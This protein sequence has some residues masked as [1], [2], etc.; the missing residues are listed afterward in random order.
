MNPLEQ[1]N[2]YLKRLERR[3]RWTAFSRGTAVTFMAALLI[4]VVLVLYTNSQAFSEASLR[5]SASLFFVVAIAMAFGARN[6]LLRLNR[7]RAAKAAE[8]AAPFNERLLT[9]AERHPAEDP[10]LELLAADTMEVA[11]SAEPGKVAGN[12]RLFG[13]L[14]AAG[15]AGLTLVWLVLSGPGYWGH[16]ASL[17]WAGT[18]REGSRA[19]FYEV[20]VAPGDKTVR[21]KGDQIVTAQL[22]GFESRKATVY[23][24]F[25]GTTKW[26]QVP[27]QPQQ[28]GSG[29]EFLFAGLPDSVQYYV[30][31]GGIRSRQYQLTAIDLPAVKK[32]RVTYK[33][34]RWIGLKDT[35]EDPGGDIRAVEGTDAYLDVQFDKPLKAG[36]L[37]LDDGTRIEL[38]GRE[39]NWMQARVPVRKDGMYHIASAARNEDVR[40]TQDYFIEAQKETPPQVKIIR[41][42]KDYKAN[43]VEE[44]TLAIEAQ[45]D[46][47]LQE[48]E[49]RY[50][51]NGGQEKTLP[52]L[53]HRGAKSADGEAVIALEDFKLTPGDIVSVYARAKDA[54]AEATSDIVFI[55]AQPFEREYSQS[56]MSGGG[57]GGAEAEDQVAQRQKK[58]LQQPSIK[59]RP[60]QGQ[61]GSVENSKFLSEMQSSRDQTSRLPSN[62]EQGNWLGRTRSSKH[63][64]DMDAATEA[65]GT[66]AEAQVSGLERCDSFRTKSAPAPAAS[67]SARRQIQVPSETGA[68]VGVVAAPVVT[69]KASSTLSWIRRR[70]SMRPGSSP[71]QLPRRR[72]K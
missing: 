50:S 49:L 58:S 70:I 24:K 36:S 1:V 33:Y 14:T 6:P 60:G 45:D 19:A 59:S 55:E 38:E 10:F 61:S 22:V 31:A 21:R 56:Q 37:L 8:N 3:L 42:G 48:L 57:G 65:M 47:G 29:F 39:G 41:P 63:I 32:I 27:M 64:R 52:L 35:T 54:R 4:T 34:P 25:A 46:F 69:W 16:G 13:S 62:E 11:R 17:L 30:D 23:A 26:E 51:V 53:K 18:P 28:S 15:L 71:P 9:F 20:V 7:K 44:V 12:R 68:V 2:N 67:R 72:K 40:L 5:G 66:A 43:P